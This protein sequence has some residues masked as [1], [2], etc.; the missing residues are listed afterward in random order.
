MLS[1]LQSLTER[2]VTTKGKVPFRRI[3]VVWAVKRN[4]DLG[5]V[6]S[7][8]KKA[9]AELQAFGFE[10]QLSLFVTA[11]GVIETKE[12]TTNTTN[13]NAAEFA[14]HG[15]PPIEA[16][17]QDLL[18]SAS[19]SCGVAVCGPLGMATRARLAVASALVKRGGPDVHLHVEG[20]SF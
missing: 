9:Q 1:L 5:W 17:L 16:I 6:A 15:R 8:L 20:F 2:V 10:V 4:V 11:E 13:F 3:H 18:S 7:D 12:A 19:G 14:Q